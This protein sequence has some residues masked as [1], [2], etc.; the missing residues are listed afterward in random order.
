MVEHPA[1]QSG[2][3][4]GPS[5]NMCPHNIEFFLQ[6]NYQ[7]IINQQLHEIE[8]RNAAAQQQAPQ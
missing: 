4:Q 2:S 6:P 5:T 8:Q 1:L 7:D 3:A